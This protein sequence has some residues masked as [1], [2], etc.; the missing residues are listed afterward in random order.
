MSKILIIS[1]SG[2]LYGS[3]RVLLDYLSGT[4]MVFD[5]ALPKHSLLAQEAA[6]TLTGHR[7]LYFTGGDTKQFY[8][9]LFFRLLI[10]K[11]KT[12]YI[13]E[14]GHGKYIMLMAR[15]FKSKHFVIHV[16]IAED[17]ATSRW[18]CFSAHNTR[19]I[20]ISENIRKKLPCESMLLYD[21]YHF[22]K[23][24]KPLTVSAVLPI[25]TIGIIGRIGFSKGLIELGRVIEYLQQDNRRNFYRF[26]LYGEIPAALINHP[27]IEKL[28]QT[29]NVLFMGFEAS[30]K[31]IYHNID[32]VLHMSKTEPLGRIFLEAIDE[33]KPFIGF[34]SDGIAEIGR[35]TGLD[36]L[37]CDPVD[38][39]FPEAFVTKLEH[40][41]NQYG[42]CVAAVAEGKKKAI[43]VFN[44]AL[45]T[46]QLDKV[47]AG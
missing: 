18:R 40:I 10:G 33:G 34:N 22:S 27:V 2:N 15:F 13:N 6:K 21:L 46:A 38:D 25:L 24:D 47:L 17:T 35:L 36:A 16:R 26:K 20:S 3:E 29:G 44:A 45:Y 5:V 31:N 39:N 7:L 42:D 23:E 1:P 12:V 28:K 9:R 4:Q 19:V 30:K 43:H 37:L 32:M 8:T 41:R 14:A 11:Y